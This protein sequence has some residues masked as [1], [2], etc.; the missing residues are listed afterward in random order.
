MRRFVFIHICLAWDFQLVLSVG[1]KDTPTLGL[2]DNPRVLS[3]G[4]VDFT[5]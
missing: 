3:K 5:A 1:W 2:K 4:N